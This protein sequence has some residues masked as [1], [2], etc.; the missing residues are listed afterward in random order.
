M[1]CLGENIVRNVFLDIGRR[2]IVWLKPQ[3]QSHK[4]LLIDNG[5]LFN[6][7]VRANVSII[8]MITRI[9]IIISFALDCPIDRRNEKKTD[10]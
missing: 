6:Y 5:A 9:T 1:Y 7:I 10:Y 3:A 2:E 8:I 4:V